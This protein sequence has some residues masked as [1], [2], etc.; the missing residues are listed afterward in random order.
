M[1]IKH[2]F[3]RYG[4][5]FSILEAPLSGYSLRSNNFQGGMINHQ[6]LKKVF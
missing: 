3:L 6:S 1:H 4:Q 5:M 2:I